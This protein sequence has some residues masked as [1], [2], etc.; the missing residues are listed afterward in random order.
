M[1]GDGVQLTPVAAW[2]APGDALLAY[3]ANND[4]NRCYQATSLST[5]GVA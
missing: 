5:A 4:G 3:D 1:N 2:A